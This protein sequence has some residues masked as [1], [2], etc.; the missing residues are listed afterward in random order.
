MMIYIGLLVFLGIAFGA[1]YF[2]GK[3]DGKKSAESRSN[4]QAIEDALKANKR[5]ETRNNMSLS[6]IDEQLLKSSR[7]D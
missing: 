1:I 7:K 5:D 4:K 2:I 3:Q 6:D